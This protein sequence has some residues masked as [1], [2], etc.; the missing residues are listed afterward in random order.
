MRELV[1]VFKALSDKNR[2]RIL[3]ML[4]SKKMCVCELAAA[5]GITQPSVSKHLSILKE[6][7]LV[8]DT[9]DG[10]WIDYTLFVDSDNQYAQIILCHLHDWINDDQCI[11]KDMS[12]IKTLSREKICK[13]NVMRGS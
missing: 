7:G 9:R 4:Q 8:H 1:K 5:L 2:L 10:Q 12:K 11:K 6:A 13:K 3:K